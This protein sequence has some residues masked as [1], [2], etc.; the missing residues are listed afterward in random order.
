ML[1]VLLKSKDSY[2]KFTI[3]LGKIV[4][5][6]HETGTRSHIVQY[7][8]LECFILHKTVDL[9]LSSCVSCFLD[10]T[11]SLHLHLFLF[12]TVNLLWYLLLL[13]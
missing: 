8:Y 12:I 7:F 1:P 10:K 4:I 2:L 6:V 5:S 3:V 9:F 13:F 11:A